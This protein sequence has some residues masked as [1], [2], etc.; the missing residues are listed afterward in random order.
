MVGRFAGATFLSRMERGARQRIMLLLIILCYGLGYSISNNNLVSTA[1]T[2]LFIF[3]LIGFRLGEGR[4]AKTLGVFGAAVIVCVLLSVSTTGYFA[5]W[6]MIVIGMF[7][8]IMFPTIFRL[9]IDGLKHKTSAGAS[10]LVSAIVGGAIIP[11]I[12][13]Y[14]IKEVGFNL[15]YSFL[16]P[17]I[18]Y[19]FISYYGFSTFRKN[20]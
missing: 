12:Q 2:I 5:M 9:G 16:F 6:T 3:N 8:S 18:C 4:S 14:L 1:F 20:G 13:T 10:L 7:N 19:A 15:Q 11:V 17:V